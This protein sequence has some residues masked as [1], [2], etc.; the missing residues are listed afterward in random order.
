MLFRSLMQTESIL[1]EPYYT[2]RLE[3]PEECLGR[4]MTD[5][6]MR[7]G[8]MQ[9]PEMTD[10]Y[11]ALAGKA[12]VSAMQE[13]AKEVSAYTKGRGRLFLSYGGYDLCRNQEEAVREIGYDAGADVEN[14]S[15]SV[16]CSHGAGTVI[17]WDHVAEWMHLESALPKKTVE[18]PE[19]GGVKQSF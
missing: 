6:K 1:L 17:E 19:E 15:S 10:E 3:V 8:T 11:A 12:P 18:K 14:P 4:A 2:Y 5:I 16:F 7:L 13:Y 9:G